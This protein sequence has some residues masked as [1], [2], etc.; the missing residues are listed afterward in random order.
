MSSVKVDY[1]FVL[2][3]EANC[4]EN[5]RLVCQEIIEFPVGVVNPN[6][7]CIE[8]TFHHYVRPEV[9]PTLTDFC[10][11]LTGITQGQVSDALTLSEVLDKF[12]IWVNE[13]YSSANWVFVT[14]GDWDL[15]TCLPREA[16]FKK[17][18]YKPY[19]KSYINIKKVFPNNPKG[20]LEMLQAMKIPHTGRH[21]SGIDDVRNI[22]E[23]L[24]GM[25]RAGVN[26]VMENIT[27]LK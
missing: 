9:V 2:D 15:R 20:M 24:I 23:V 26:I 12:D 16:N 3:F 18:Q 8:N 14:C 4:I 22:A 6:S 25:L 17:I 7:Y 13:N 1:Y 21:H 19:F 10:T 11:Q 5:G 27:V